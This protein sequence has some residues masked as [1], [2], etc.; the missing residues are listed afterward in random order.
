MVQIPSKFVISSTL[1]VGAIYK[2]VAPEFI[3]TEIPHF[4]VVVA[5]NEDDNFMLVSTTQ[6]D[7]RITYFNKVGHNLNS[8]AYIE[9]TETNGLTKNSYFDCNQYYTITK[10]KLEQK[11]TKDFLKPKGHLNQEEYQKLITSIH[12]SKTNDIPRFLLSYD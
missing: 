6:L 3:N 2:M 9:P 8:L 10:D 11:V 1:K 12:T 7:K 4:F 5:I